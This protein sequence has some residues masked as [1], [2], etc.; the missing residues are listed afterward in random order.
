MT[1]PIPNLPKVRTWHNGK[2]SGTFDLGH[3]RQVNANNP[4]ARK[5]I[6][7]AVKDGTSHLA[8]STDCWEFEVDSANWK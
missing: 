8:T 2:Y 7:Q 3:L 5:A 1:N 6:E 4:Q